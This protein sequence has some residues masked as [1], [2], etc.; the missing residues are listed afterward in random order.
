[1]TP[2]TLNLTIWRGITL[3]PIIFNVKDGN[4]NP[5]SLNGWQVFANSRN[6]TGKLINLNPTITNANNGQ[7]TISLSANDTK[8]FN[9]GEQYWDLIF[10][11]PG[12]SRLGPYISGKIFVKDTVTNA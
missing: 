2:A 7:V 11:N 6:G 8:N 4:G 10:Q 5:V 3:D 1:M 12:G 9:A